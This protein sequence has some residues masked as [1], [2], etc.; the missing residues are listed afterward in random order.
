M[1]SE[2]Q[3]IK[4][5]L[6]FAVSALSTEHMIS[7]GMSSPWS[8]AKFASSAEDKAQVSKLYREAMYASLVVT[9]L[10]AWLL[11]SVEVL[12]WGLAGTGLVAIFVWSEYSRALRGEL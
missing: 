3:G 1:P 8:V 4:N 2:L 6:G 11:D 5:A 12:V 10:T 9:A 7:A